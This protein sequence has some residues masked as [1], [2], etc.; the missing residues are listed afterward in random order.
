MEQSNQQSARET[1]NVRESGFFIKSE[2]LEEIRPWYI[3]SQ[4]EE[5]DNDGS[6]S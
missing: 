2:D 6:D 1:I 3:E 5:A 4:S